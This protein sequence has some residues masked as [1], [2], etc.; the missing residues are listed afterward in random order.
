MAPLPRSGSRARESGGQSVLTPRRG[1]CQRETLR[2]GLTGRWAGR[3]SV[4]VQEQ[5]NPDLKLTRSRRELIPRAG[6]AA[7]LPHARSSRPGTSRANPSLQ[8]DAG[9]ESRCRRRPPVPPLRR[10]W[11]KKFSN[12][13]FLFFFLSICKHPPSPGSKLGNEVWP[14][15]A[16]RLGNAHSAI[17]CPAPDPL[18]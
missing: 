9:G 4:T 18:T 11:G 14:S 17:P 12:F 6:R 1:G 10:C 3:G 15:R 16:R 8:T 13:F 7:P 2:P 5:S